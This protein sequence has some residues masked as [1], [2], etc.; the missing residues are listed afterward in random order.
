MK[1]QLKPLMVSLCMLGMTTVPAFAAATADSQQVEKL[2]QQVTQLQQEVATLKSQ[3]VAKKPQPRAKQFNK[4]H[5]GVKTGSSATTLSGPSTL[6]IAG[7]KYLPA[8]VDIPGQSFVTSGPYTG[9]PLEYAGTDLIINSPSVNEDVTLLKLR[10][11]I[12]QRLTALGQPSETNNPHVLLS[13][14]AEAAA[15]Y[16]KPYTGKSQTDIDLTSAKLDAY[17]LGP[18]RWTSAFMEFAYS[19]A[20][21]TSEGSLNSNAREQNSRVFINKAFIIVGDFEQ[22]PFY[23]SIGQM[24]VPFGSYSSSMVSS[25]LTLGMART[26]ARAVVLGYSPQED[27]AFSAAVYGFKG[28]SRTSTNSRINNG[29]ID[30]L[31]HFKSGDMS[32]KVGGGIIANI[33][34]SGGMQNVG[35]SAGV[36]NGFGGAT[37]NGASTGNEQLVHCVPAVDIRGQLAMG[38]QV[39]LLAEYITATKRFNPNDLSISSHGAKPQA[40]NA[41]AVY[42][43]SGFEKP[44]SVSLGYGMTRDALAL[45]LP[46]QRYSLAFNT[47]FWRDTL[48]SLE[49]RRDYDY[50][51][52][53][54]STGSGITSSTGTG[55]A[56]NVVTA[57]FDVYF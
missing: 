38:E 33:A 13:G 18:S 32:G 25:P 4:K 47:S 55:K 8:D 16:Q 45:G 9:I 53:K 49:F 31:Y 5:T 27:N 12:H 11:N 29:G 21:G 26:K 35:N 50:A 56:N 46:A 42:T 17:I 19:N 39:D 10:K 14:M 24:N 1:R 41:E 20:A 3:M 6:P 40:L 44:T 51:S 15:S 34:D 30:L 43:F 28:D 48:Q 2:S 22:S 23:G 52:G 7:G 57:Q 37:V 54:T 36:F